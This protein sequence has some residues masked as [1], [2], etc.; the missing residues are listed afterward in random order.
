MHMTGT[1]SLLQGSSEFS[2]GETHIIL[3][4]GMKVDGVL[5]AAWEHQD[6]FLGGDDT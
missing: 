6:T 3:R 4:Q 5:S 1:L 2:W